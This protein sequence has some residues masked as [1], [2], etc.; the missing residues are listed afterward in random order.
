MRRHA[1][2]DGSFLSRGAAVGNANWHYSE[3]GLL[4]LFDELYLELRSGSKIRYNCEAVA[5]VKYC[6]QVEFLAQ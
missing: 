6:T 2:A 3:S 5:G 1:C 4:A